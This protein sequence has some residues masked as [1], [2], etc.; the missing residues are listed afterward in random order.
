MPAHPWRSSLLGLTFWFTS[1]HPASRPVWLLITSRLCVSIHVLPCKYTVPVNSSSLLIHFLTANPR[2]SCVLLS[3]S[4]MFC[5]VRVS[6]V[7]V[8][9]DL[10]VDHSLQLPRFKS[11]NWNWDFLYY[12]LFYR[13][14]ALT[15]SYVQWVPRSLL[16]LFWLSGTSAVIHSS[17]MLT[18]TRSLTQGSS[19]WKT[20]RGSKLP[21]P[22]VHYLSLSVVCQRLVTVWERRLFGVCMYSG[23]CVCGGRGK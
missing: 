17:H 2:V 14:T 10:A 12:V 23:V 21:Q 7:I 5:P 20:C 16:L 15:G 3:L 22:W 18:A 11:M 6:V 8:R 13:P 1:Q 9:Y 19:L 4:D